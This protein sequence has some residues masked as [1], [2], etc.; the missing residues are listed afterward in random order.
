[1]DEKKDMPQVIMLDPYKLWKKIYFS[2][3]QVWTSAYRDFIK[4]D[5]FANSIDLILNTYLQYLRFQNDI[6]DRLME[7]SPL[8]SKRD[9]ARV[10]ELVVSLENKVDGI[11]LDVD[12]KLEDLDSNVCSVRDTANQEDLIRRMDRLEALMADLNAN[13]KALDQ[14]LPT[15]PKTGRAATKKPIAPKTAPK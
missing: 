3:E 11:E 8:A 6:V 13:L 15:E 12:E 7:E 2:N 5:V 9:V 1:M 4:T 14:K 10:A